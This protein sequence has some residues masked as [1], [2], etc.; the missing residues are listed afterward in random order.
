[1][2]VTRPDATLG[3][4]A[5]V[6]AGLGMRALVSAGWSGMDDG[7]NDGRV[8]VVPAVNH[9]AVLPR[10]T[11]AVHHGGSGTTAASLRAGLPTMVCSVFADQP[12]WGTQVERL[13]VGSHVRFAALTEQT[14]SDGLGKALEPAVRHR[15]RRLAESLRAESGAT[16]RAADIVESRRNS[17]VRETSFI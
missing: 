13:G 12:F 4:I 11:L 5:K 8:R 7:G 6:T 10:C 16:M 2:P 14:L 17:G 9:D 15:A 3:M 1:M